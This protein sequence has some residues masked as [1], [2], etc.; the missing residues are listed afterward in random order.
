[1]RKRGFRCG[2]LLLSLSL[3]TLPASAADD[4]KYLVAPYGWIAGLDGESTIRGVTASVEADFADIIENLET[5]ALVHFEAEKGRWTVLS[6]L[7]FIAIGQ[8]TRG[9]IDVDFDVDQ[10]I[11]ELG[12]GYNLS[13]SFAVLFGGRYVDG[14]VD[15]DVRAPLDVRVRRDKD[16]IDPYVGGRFVLD[17]GRRWD[18]RVRG[19]VG[20]FGVGSEFTWNLA[21][22]WVYRASRRVS[23]AFGYR[24]LDIDFEEGSGR[25]LFRYDVRMFGPQIGAAFHF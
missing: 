19:D 5:A 7:I 2:G 12:G 14:K 22:N 13:D 23:L 6:D 11:V 20:G 8:T 18:F 21:L 17:L 1:M 9:A 15:L 10:T 25:D 24:A 16:W 4:W 3:V